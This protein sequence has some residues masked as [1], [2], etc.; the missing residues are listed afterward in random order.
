MNKYLLPPFSQSLII[1][2]YTV[3]VFLTSNTAFARAH[4]PLS[5]EPIIVQGL[6]VHPE[7]ETSPDEFKAWLFAERAADNVATGKILLYSIRYNKNLDADSQ[8]VY[9]SSL[10]EEYDTIIA[11][12]ERGHYYAIDPI[13]GSLLKAKN[14]RSKLELNFDIAGF[15]FKKKNYDQAVKILEDNRQSCLNLFGPDDLS[16]AYCDARIAMIRY[17]QGQDADALP[18]YKRAL[19]S[20]KKILLASEASDFLDKQIKSALNTANWNTKDYPIENTYRIAVALAKAKNYAES[21]A[22]FKAMLKQFDTLPEDK[23]T[24]STASCLLAGTIFL[25]EQKQYHDAALILSRALRNYLQTGWGKA[26][27]SAYMADI[28]NR[29][30]ATWKPPT[31]KVNKCAIVD[32]Q[33]YRDGTLG[34]F[35]ISQSSGSAQFDQAAVVSVERMAPFPALPLGSCASVIVGLTFNYNILNRQTVPKNQS[36]GQVSPAPFK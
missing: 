34:E 36:D 12:D 25:D 8:Q 9:L 17:E 32:F 26:D 2:L 30:R 14:S 4:A 3:L 1:V 13:S 29:I 20:A 23:H 16:P 15:Y 24:R 11:Q 6:K 22:E 35:K 33:I 19:S 28:Q 21:T 7:Y 27:Y 31:Q 5:I 10:K 18:F